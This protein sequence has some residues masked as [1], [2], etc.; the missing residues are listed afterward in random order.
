MASGA[1]NG[2]YDGRFTFDSDVSNVIDLSVLS[3][4]GA[5]VRVFV[6]VNSGGTKMCIGAA[7]TSDGDGNGGLQI[8]NDD[9]SYEVTLFD[10]EHDINF[11]GVAGARCYGTGSVFPVTK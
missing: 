3:G 8:A 2:T 6:T 7:D 4:N 10:P 9:N 5:G 1:I 11:D